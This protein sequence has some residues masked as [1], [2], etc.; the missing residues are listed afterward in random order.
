[1]AAEPHTIPVAP[2][3]AAREHEELLVR[4]GARSGLYTVVAVHSTTLGPALGGCRMW[5]YSTP[6]DAAD[7]ALRL[8]SAMTLKAAAAGLSLGGGKGGTCRPPG[9]GGP[10]G[11]ARRDAPPASAD[12]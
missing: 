10:Q 2:P 1:M 9:P 3:V 7:D 5:H 12:P 6:T 4:C 8:S 11:G